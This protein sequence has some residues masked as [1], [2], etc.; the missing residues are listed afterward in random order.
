[1]RA[2][3]EPLLAELLDAARGICRSETAT[4]RNPSISRRSTAIA[5]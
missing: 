3:V 1:M 2:G 4:T 5:S